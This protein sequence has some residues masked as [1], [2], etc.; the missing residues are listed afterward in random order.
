MSQANRLI[1][2]K[3]AQAG[4]GASP[5]QRVLYL[6][7]GLALCEFGSAVPALA[8]SAT[9]PAPAAVPAAAATTA[10]QAAPAAATTAPKV[11]NV[12]G[13]R[14]TNRIDRQVY[15]V[16]QDIN[17]SNGSAADALGNVPSVAVD[18]DGTVSLRGST[19]VQILV[20]GKPSAMLQGDN[21]GPALQAMPADDIDSVEVINNPGA[22]FGNEG[23]G[24]PILNLVMKRNRKPGGF[25]VANAN[26]GTAGRYNA[27][28]S[29]S[30]N[31]G[32]WGFQGGVNVR[33][34]GR[35]S[36]SDSERE[37]V[38]PLT[39]DT[40]RSTTASSS[41][42]L[43][44][45]TGARGQVSYNLGQDD[46]LEANFAV[47][48][49][50]NDQEGLDRYRVVDED[51]TPTSDY[52]RST[53]R[54]GDNTNKMFGARW[55]HKGEKLGESFKMDLRVSDSD[56]SNATDYANRYL[57]LPPFAADSRNLQDDAG[58]TKIVDYT[59]DY[60]R[61][62]ESGAILKLGWKLYDNQT[63]ADRRYYDFDLATGAQT[64]NGRRTNA[65][66]YEERDTALYT[67]YQWRVNERWGALLGLRAEH[68]D[69]DIGAGSS[70][71]AAAGNSYLNWMPSAF[72]TYKLDDKTNLRFSYARR[73]RRPQPNDLN[74]F[75]RYVDELNESSGNPFLKPVK[76]DS[77]EVGYETKAAGLD[78]N[79]RAYYR[80]DSDM[81]RS[82]Q[83]AVNDTVILTTQENG[84]SNRSGGLE[85]TLSGKLTPKLSINTSGNVFFAQQQQIDITGAENKRS[86]T[87]LNVRGRFTYQLTPQ[88]MVQLMLNAQGKTL[89]GAGYR[90]PSATANVTWKRSLTPAL[91]LV[92]TVTDLFDSQKMETI[93][94]S[95]TLKEHTIRR[96]DGRI[97]YVGLSYRF[98]GVQSR[99]EGA[100]GE[101]WR[102]GPP[103][104]MGGPP[105]GGPGGG[106]GP[107]GGPGM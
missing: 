6:A 8:Q 44:D 46:T 60:E 51:G 78:A 107:G 12:V 32:R 102:R 98:G 90:Q 93:T 106:F 19:N 24:G 39:G 92:A 67:S 80:N 62:L 26:V 76:T 101:G 31:T 5:R 64:L 105:P 57:V 33:H 73:I 59:G 3:Q 21:R 97:V 30:Y 9:A 22:E 50:T 82:R 84:G 15:D 49:R 61:P 35:N 25:G 91:S 77:L 43:N 104:G 45:N 34:D 85:F 11:V 1:H 65:F 63:D 48:K 55:D 14:P 13:E 17:A 4:T 27:A 47:M 96:F 87:S 66:A 69:M 100:D 36:T 40:Q 52:Y 71:T 10:A 83:Y 81:I 58:A 88:D 41:A 74:P 38:D 28:L 99:R 89:A 53:Q 2:S 56:T 72:A 16:K 75:V 29:G 7:V 54:S 79:V 37:R 70:G 23:G 94:D 103:G 68:T 18:P 42:G 20:D 95:A 86:A